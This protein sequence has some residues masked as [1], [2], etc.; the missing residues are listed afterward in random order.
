MSW[1]SIGK[2]SIALILLIGLPTECFAIVS[3][4]GPLQPLSQQTNVDA[5]KAKL[6]KEL[7]YSPRLSKDN[8]VSCNSC[9]NLQMSGTDGKPKAIGP[10]NMVSE[11]NTPTVLNSGL[12]FR[13]FWDGR[14][15]N[16]NELLDSHLESKTIMDTKWQDVIDKLGNDS[17]LNAEFKHSY[18]NGLTK[19]SAKEVIAEFINTLT[20]PNTRYDRYLRGDLTSLTNEEKEGLVRFMSIG[21]TSC[22]QGTNLGGNLFA[23]L[24]VTHDYFAEKGGSNQADLGR[25]NQTKREE[26]KHVFKV[27][28]LRNVTLTAPYF[29][30]GAVAS[31][32]DAV[33]LM[34]KYQLGIELKAEEI[35]SIVRFLKALEGQPHKED[36]K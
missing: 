15:A 16:L 9:H 3:P 31:I 23:K 6:G 22:H 32:E 18:P 35:A 28:S 4:S 30:D 21:C 26:D 27:P 14:A 1:F 2:F 13:Q 33:R 29:H 25:Y 5:K 10:D 17:K 19:E 12:F 8:Q 34:A 36:A 20:T 11:F 7:F 24:G